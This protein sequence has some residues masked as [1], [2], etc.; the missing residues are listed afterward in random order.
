M[1]LHPDGAESEGRADETRNPTGNLDP[2]W[3][4]S[5]SSPNEG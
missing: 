2:E 4:T 5:L 1:N 3:I